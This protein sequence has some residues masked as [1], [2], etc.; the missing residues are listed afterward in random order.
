M[1]IMVLND[2]GKNFK[3]K[4]METDKRRLKPM[5]KKNVILPHNTFE[6]WTS[7]K[8]NVRLEVLKNGVEIHLE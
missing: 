3:F 5:D 1:K 7:G 8:K 6:E 4:I 2:S